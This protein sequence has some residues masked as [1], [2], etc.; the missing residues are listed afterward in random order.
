M[1]EYV[2]VYVDVGVGAYELAKE[3]KGVG[4]DMMTR[5]ADRIETRKE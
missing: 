2:R 3:R 1:Y 5:K 4:E